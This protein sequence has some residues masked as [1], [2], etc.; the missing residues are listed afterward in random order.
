[1]SQLSDIA[2]LPVLILVVLGG[3]TVVGTL[4]VGKL[5]RPQKYSEKK[6]DAYECGEKTVGPSWVNFNVRFYIIAIVF[7]IFDIEAVL[8]VP[9]A[10]VL[11]EFSQTE[12]GGPFL[13]SFL[14][15][16]LVLLVGLIYCWRK[17]DLNWIKSFNPS[18]SKGEDK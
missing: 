4:L 1:M 11:K 12:Y 6:L 9:V 18:D 3:L 5:I 16:I 8:V 15:F 10:M 7:I 17:G 13:L 14:L 2:F